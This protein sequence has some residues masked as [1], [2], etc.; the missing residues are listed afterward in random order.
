VVLSGGAGLRGAGD[1]TRPE[2]SG[3]RGEKSICIPIRLEF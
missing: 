2:H 1:T 3:N